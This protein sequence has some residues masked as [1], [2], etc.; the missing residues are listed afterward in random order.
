[1]TKKEQ[2]KPLYRVVNDDGVEFQF[3]GQVFASN[4]GKVFVS[5]RKVRTKNMDG[6]LAKGRK[7][8]QGYLQI[9]LCDANGKRGWFYIHTLMGWA[10]LKKHPYQRCVLHK[11]DNPSNNI[12]TNLKWGTHKNNMHDMIK[13]GRANFFG[14]KTKGH[15]KFTYS[16]DLCIEVYEKRLNGSTFQQL[17]VE[18][19]NIKLGSLRH[20]VSGYLLVKRGLLQ[21]TIS[22]KENIVK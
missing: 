5:P 9:S 4:K 13:K 1:M 18:Y 17:K 14:Q 22:Q 6:Y 7:T 11:D 12:I 16:D 10:W 19:P 21:H 15:W 2:F 3:K 20:M 8:E